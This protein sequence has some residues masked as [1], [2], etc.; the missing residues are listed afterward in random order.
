MK[1]LLL[2]A[3]VL[4][5]AGGFLFA[6]PAIKN[7]D[8][9]IMLAPGDAVSL[10]P[11][12]AYDNV[13]WSMLAVLY[14]RLI[15]FKGA[16]LG[17]FVP[18]LATAV[19]TVANGGIS[20][21]GKSYTFTIRSGVKFANGYGLTAEDVAYTF[22]R[23]MITDPDSGPAWV[24][25]QVLLGSG[26]QSRGDDGKIAVKFSDI[27]SAVQAKGNKVVFT[28][29]NPYPAF[30]SV[31]AG[32]WGSIVSKKWLTEQGGW[33]GTEATMEKY[34]NPPTSKETLFNIANGTGPYKL[35]QWQKG[36]EIDVTRNDN[37]WGKK[38]ALKNGVYKVVDE[39]STRKLQLLQGDAD[40]IYVPATNFPEMAAE[41]GI[42]IY[43]DLAALDL[44][45]AHFNLKINDKGNSNI[46]SGKLDGQGIPTD[47]FA[48][49]DV[50]M[51]FIYA[52]DEQQELKD[53]FNGNAVD[54][55]TFLPK[56]LPYKN[57]KLAS[58]PHDMEK[59][60]AAFQK[61]FGGQ[62]WDKGFKFDILFNSGNV[63]RETAAHILAENV[64]ALNS[65]FQISVR[66]LEWS[67][68]SDENKNKRVPILFMGWAP[69]YPDP[70]DY[71]QPYMSSSGYFAGR[72][73]YNNAEADDLVAKASVELN[74]A[75][76]QQ[77][78]YRLQDIWLQDAI[79]IVFEQP[80]R[81]RFLK[82]WVKG[83]YYSP[84]ESQE[85]E[86]LPILSKSAN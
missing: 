66:G 46:G 15:D 41:K 68:Y 72:Q 37:Y 52:W 23:D 82:D 57:P 32:K 24:W 25:Y 81:Q 85:F 56:G 10:D 12:V 84:M 17:T 61:A 70:D 3:S 71:A 49:K 14:D 20:K 16:D 1:R 2:L 13:S 53:G 83:Y 30:L 80:L 42:K 5:M 19:P 79:A 74:A 65:K 75:K 73:G 9:L 35:Q 76:R 45:G 58:V 60:K 43:K 4:L 7:A 11:A 29:K 34:N 54:P 21:D 39:M 69:D 86:L 6:A 28:L 67:Q 48:D 77:Y 40:I 47:F 31:I 36:V 55:V 27:A 8:T 50:R 59:A 64:M 33:D 26:S 18:M 62:V 44:T 22:Q 38:P 78:Y 63:E 51:G